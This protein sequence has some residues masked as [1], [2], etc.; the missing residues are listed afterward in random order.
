[1]VNA[2]SRNQGTDDYDLK[3]RVVGGIVLAIL[4]ILLYLILKALLG[5]SSTGADYALRAPLPDEI[6]QPESAEE[7]APDAETASGNLGRSKYPIIN[8]FVFLDL[9]G[10][11]ME[12]GVGSDTYI[13]LVESSDVNFEGTGVERWYVQIA[14]LRD[15]NA[16]QDLAKKLNEN[17][18][19]AV[20][21]KLGNW[22]A[23]RLPPRDDKNEAK[24]DWRTARN[25]AG[26][27][28][29]SRKDPVIKSI[30]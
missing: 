6:T 11:V 7:A 10:K 2:P 24:Q 27:L 21:V 26:K 8:K 25:L 16:A 28:G 18:L 15:I 1:M 4:L 3:Q 29:I 20:V 13:P 19:P 9:Q 30:K 5:I 12:E 22:H 23:V 14:S 17:Q